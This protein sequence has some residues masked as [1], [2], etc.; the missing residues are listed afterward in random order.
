MIR[1]VSWNVNGLRAIERKGNFEEVFSLNSDV[2]CLQEIK[3]SPDQLPDNLLNIPGY[4]AFFNPSKARKGYSGTAIYSRLE[5]LSVIAGL[6]EE[7]FDVEGRTQIADFGSFVLYNIYYPNGKAS[8]E[9]LQFKLDFYEYFH[10]HVLEAVNQGKSIVICGDVNTAHKEIDL[11][12]PKEN[13]AVSGFLPVE[14]EFLTR[15][16]DSGFVDTFRL[17][18]KEGGHYTWWDYV[19]RARERNVGWRIDYFYVNQALQDKVLRSDIH[20]E[21]QGSDHCP[22][23]IDLDL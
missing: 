2:L 3:S 9:R 19:T 18:E 4:H 23:S 12:R 10:Q 5:P 7:R 15:F 11:A 6:G 14:R 16:L 8:G 22:I 20:S 17:F 13:A 1:L 21:I